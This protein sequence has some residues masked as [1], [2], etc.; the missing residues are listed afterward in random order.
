[1]VDNNQLTQDDLTDL[2]EN[3]KHLVPSSNGEKVVSKKDKFSDYITIFYLL[4]P[5]MSGIKLLVTESSSIGGTYVTIP[6]IVS[7]IFVFIYGL[8]GVRKNANTNDVIHRFVEI[9]YIIPVFLYSFETIFYED[10]PYIT[11]NPEWITIP[12]P[13][14]VVI[15]TLIGGSI[16]GT[17]IWIL[18]Q[19][20]E[21]GTDEK[22]ED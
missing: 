21:I 4:T 22:K 20:M 11:I 7:G 1:M 6:L 15:I 3:I 18:F 12:I 17:I 13:E 14:Y 19:V 16:L 5:S 10:D 8:L 9:V 2:D